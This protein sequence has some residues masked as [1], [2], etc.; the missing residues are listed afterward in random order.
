MRVD[1]VDSIESSSVGLSLPGSEH[2]MEFN[3]SGAVT[4]GETSD[5]ETTSFPEFLEVNQGMNV[6]NSSLDWSGT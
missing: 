3:S 5:D 6:N 2:F 4:E 1:D